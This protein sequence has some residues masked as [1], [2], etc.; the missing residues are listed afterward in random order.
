[1]D[2]QD[3]SFDVYTI[4]MTFSEDQQILIKLEQKENLV[5]TDSTWTGIPYTTQ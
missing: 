1:M 4:V 3:G 5:I 2:H